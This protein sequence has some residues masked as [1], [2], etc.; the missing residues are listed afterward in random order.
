MNRSQLHVLASALDGDGDALAEACRMDPTGALARRHRAGPALYIAARALENPFDCE[1]WHRE[2]HENAVRSAILMESLY[3]AG[4]VLDRAGLAWAPLKGLDL[5]SRVY[6]EP[7]ERPTGDV[8]ILVFPS[9]GDRARQALLEAGWKELYQGQRSARYTREEGYA[10]QLLGAN[11]VLLELHFRL[12]GLIPTGY[13]TVALAR[14]TPGEGGRRLRWADAYVVAAA[15]FWTVTPP[16]PLIG[17]R[18][19]HLCGK[20]LANAGEVVQ[21]TIDWDLQAQVAMAAALSF[22]FWQGPVCGEIVQRLKPLLR[23]SEQRLFEGWQDDG[24]HLDLRWRSLALARLLAG[25][26]SRAGWRVAWRRLW[27]HAGL[28]ERATPEDWPWWRR[29]ARFQKDWW[30]PGSR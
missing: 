7:E 12:W 13:E 21:I 22:E 30:L 5:G 17:L 18:D 20:S 2:L 6:N 27:P 29:R 24:A 16:R 19:L 28:A 25:R 3:Q 9:D 8:D 23:R 4:E 11:G 14:A 26:R 15:H 1:S 10:W